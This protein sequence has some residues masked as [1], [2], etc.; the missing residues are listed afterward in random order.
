MISRALS[1]LFFLLSPNITKAESQLLGTWQS[2]LEIS[3]TK[4]KL[5]LLA[6]NT[7]SFIQQIVG[8]LTIT[9]ETDT[10]VEYSPSKILTIEGK[11]FEWAGA[12]GRFPYR[13]L[14]Q[15][16][17]RVIIKRRLVDG[18]WVKSAITFENPDLYLVNWKDHSDVDFDEYFVRQ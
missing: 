16:E 10:L 18:S 17:D 13:V 1:A 6:P 15:L 12:N 9:Y 2:S 11:D 14:Q 4:N 8:E 5:E 7:L 3:L